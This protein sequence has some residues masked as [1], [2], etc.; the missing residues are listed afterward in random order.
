MAPPKHV[1]NPGMLPTPNANPSKDPMSGSM[2]PA[3]TSHVTSLQT[4]CHQTTPIEVQLLTTFISKSNVRNAGQVPLDWSF[5]NPTH[6]P[7]GNSIAS[8][9]TTS[10]KAKLEL[11]IP[12][13]IS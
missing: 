2:V 12:Q 3:R 8:K 4:V 7:V 1:F 10:Q 9:H 5:M 6:C 13:T 11:L